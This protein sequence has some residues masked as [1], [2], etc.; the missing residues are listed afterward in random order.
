MTLRAGGGQGRHADRRRRSERDLLGD[1]VLVG[2]LLHDRPADLVGALHVDVALGRAELVDDCRRTALLQIRNMALR[3]GVGTQEQGDNRKLHVNLIKASWP[4]SMACTRNM[5]FM[6]HRAPWIFNY[7]RSLF[8]RIL[9]CPLILQS[10]FMHFTLLQK[11]SQK[12]NHY[13]H[14]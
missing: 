13:F 5:S 3:A 2:G 8:L 12:H 7:F 10:S 9:Q 14:E 6:G 1:D 4:F 11:N